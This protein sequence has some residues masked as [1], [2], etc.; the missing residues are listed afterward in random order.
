MTRRCDGIWELEIGPGEDIKGKIS[1]FIRERGWERAGICGALGSVKNVVLTTPVSFEL[2]PEVMKTPC[3][4]PG[5]VLAFSGEVM[6]ADLM[7]PMLKKIYPG[8]E[9]FFIH[10]H[11]SLAV[12]GAHVYGG[13]LEKG[14]VFRG[15]K[16][17]LIH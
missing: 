8:G 7:D 6:R 11:I 14:S 5:E 9:P 17:Y 4:G 12:P 2:P 10:I 13:G 1:E 16:V 15:L 3:G